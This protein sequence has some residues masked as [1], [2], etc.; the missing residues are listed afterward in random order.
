VAFALADLLVV[1]GPRG[2]V[3]QRRERGEEEGSFELL[4]SPPGR[5]LTADRGARAP[6][7][8]GETCVGGQVGCSG[9]AAGVADVDEEPGSGPYADPRHGRQ[10]L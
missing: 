9:K 7:R 10:D 5:L 1:V 4:V 6:R 3:G 2:R 8:W